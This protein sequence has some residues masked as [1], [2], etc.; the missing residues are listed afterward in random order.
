MNP[1]DYTKDNGVGGNHR[2][3]NMQLYSGKAFYPND[4]RPEEIDIQDIA[5]SLANQCRYNG[6]TKRFYSVAEHSVLVAEMVAQETLD[7]NVIRQALMHD[8]PE[9]Y[10]GDIIRPLKLQLTEWEAF[11]IPVWEAICKRYSMN[12]KFDSIVHKMDHASC[13]IEKRDLMNPSIGTCWG[14]LPEADERF[15]VIGLPPDEAKDLFLQKF[16]TLFG[17]RR[18]YSEWKSLN[19]PYTSDFFEDLYE[20]NEFEPIW[21]P[22]AGFRRG[23]GN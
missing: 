20:E 12:S 9:A 21:N 15:S 5:H 6:H 18:W 7:T 17:G 8:A 19:Y 10:V 3:L 14:N 11:E 1:T 4:P 13:S 22:P 2:G 16:W 23:N